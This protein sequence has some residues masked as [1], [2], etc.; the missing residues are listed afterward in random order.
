MRT[1]NKPQAQEEVF[2]TLKVEEETEHKPPWLTPWVPAAP[3]TDDPTILE[4]GSAPT[5]W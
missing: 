3:K 1:M 4:R 2:Q 5:A